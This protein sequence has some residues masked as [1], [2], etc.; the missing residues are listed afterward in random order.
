M[1]RTWLAADHHFMHKNM[2]KFTDDKGNRVREFTWPWKPQST[3]E[4][5]ELIIDLH[6][7]LVQPGDRVHLLGDITIPRKGLK[8]LER[9]NGK[10]ALTA[11]GNHDLFSTQDYLKYVDYVRGSWKLDNFLLIH[12]PCHTSCVPFWCAGVCHGHIHS[13]LVLDSRGAPDE[14]YINCCIEH[15]GGMPIDFE[16]I[17]KGRYNPALGRFENIS[18][19]MMRKLKK[20]F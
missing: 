9:L 11:A 6:N 18:A 1:N 13:K 20:E 15:T 19:E 3:A 12:I 17:R 8:L 5:D 7:R 4:N 2:Y 10:L 14:R 16:Q